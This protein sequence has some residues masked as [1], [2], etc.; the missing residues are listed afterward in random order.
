MRLKM[1]PKDCCH[2]RAGIGNGTGLKQSTQLYVY[3]E[4]RRRD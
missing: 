1:Y 4:N 2:G 3:S